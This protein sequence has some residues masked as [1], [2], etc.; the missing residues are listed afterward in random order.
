MN[1]IRFLRAHI[2]ENGHGPRRQQEQR[3]KKEILRLD[4]Q[5]RTDQIVRQSGVFQCPRGPAQRIDGDQR[6]DV[7]FFT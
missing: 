2:S 7:M 1:D 4:D 5:P 6:F 3:F